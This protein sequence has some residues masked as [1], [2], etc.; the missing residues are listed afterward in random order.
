MSS[1]RSQ[2][3]GNAVI[4]AALVL[5]A[6]LIVE[7]LTRAGAL[8]SA[9]ESW[10]PW[11][12]YLLYALVGGVVLRHSARNPIGILVALM[13]VVPLLGSVGEVVPVR[14]PTPG[15]VADLAMWIVGWYFY[16]FIGA[17]LLLFHLFPSGRPMPGMW[18]WCYRIAV[19]GSGTLVFA[20][21][22]GPPDEGINPFEIPIVSAAAPVL[23]VVIGA[24]L[25]GAFV[26]GVAALGVRFRRSRGRERAQL[27]WFFFSVMVSV[28][29]FY[30]SALLSKLIPPSL[31]AAIEGAAFTLPAVGILIA[32][33]RH[34]LFDID[35]IVS[36]TVSY[37]VVGLVVV[38]VY[39]VP[40]VVIPEVLGLSSDLSVA[41][42]TL[43]V[44]AVFNPLR[45]RV[46]SVVDRAFDRERYDAGQLV[47]AFSERL[48]SAVDLGRV[49]DELAR[50][51]FI[52]LRPAAVAVWFGEGGPAR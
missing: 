24:S 50:A 35:R 44:A 4:F 42:A 27:K 40:V 16:V 19:L 11:T 14:A 52:A 36:R 45:R 2:W 3:I 6:G 48:Q 13:G 21:L 28:A 37:A 8:R 17:V 49:T 39:G 32:V 18:R 5:Y 1:T 20:Y 34:G 31:D 41:L 47:A 51:V 23:E 9:D 15:L 7:G 25:V 43:A 33:T 10:R 46:Q 26:T 29:A 12:V 22:F 30:T 38:A